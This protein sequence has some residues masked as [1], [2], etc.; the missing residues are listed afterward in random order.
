MK[1]ILFCAVL[2]LFFSANLVFAAQPI[3]LRQA[4]G[5]AL[6]HNSNVESAREL[7]RSSSYEAKSAMGLFLP[8]IDIVGAFA[9]L[10]EPITLDLSPIRSAIIGASAAAYAGAGGASP[11]DFQQGLES[12]MPSFNK[13][14][15]D[16]NVTR[17]FASIV[18][19]IFTG[20]KVTA[21]YKVKGLQRDASRIIYQNER[22]QI[23]TL[24]I[25]DYF[26][27]KFL[28]QVIQIRKN[29]QDDID[30]HLENAKRLYKAGIINRVQ[31]L[32]AMTAAANAEVDYKASL[33]DKEIALTLLSADLGADASTLELTDNLSILSGFQD[34]DYYLL[35]LE[36][37][38]S[39]ALLNI[40]EESFKQKHKVSIGNTLPTISAVGQYQILKDELSALEPEWFLGITA[41]L[42]LFAG[43]QDYYGIKSSEVQVKAAQAQIED[44]KKR[45]AAA[46]RKFYYQCQTAKDQY[47]SL[48]VSISYANESLKLART[49]F[50]AGTATSL[51]VIDAQMVLQKAQ[52]DQAKAIFDFN[53]AFA[54]LLHLC[55]LSEA[56]FRQQ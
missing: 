42:N 44:V 33:S 18:Q 22:N 1:K 35:R 21:N 34:L 47:E 24:V 30:Q 50:R 14:L 51:E 31:V 43:G 40:Q 4:L 13:D 26:R 55:N 16:E 17:V 56:S 10:N 8:R 41:T 46:V 9:K 2:T 39:L 49:A 25:E 11:A 36:D 29:Y 20:F 15:I 19:P 12:S 23:I 5:Y 32:K 27:I 54:N 53:G 28:E 45:L 6:R 38:G 48:K 3:T 52:T 7:Y 37:N